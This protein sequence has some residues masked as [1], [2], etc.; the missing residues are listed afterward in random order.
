MTDPKEVG[1]EPEVT[2]AEMADLAG[3]NLIAVLESPDIEI[4]DALVDYNAEHG[5][6]PELEDPEEV[7]YL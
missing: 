7:K 6:N 1:A 3:L 2:E 4:V 5:A